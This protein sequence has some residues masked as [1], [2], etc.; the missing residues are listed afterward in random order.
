VPDEG[1][2][3]ADLRA[4]LAD[5]FRDGARPRVTDVLRALMAHAQ[6]DTDFRDR[7]RASFLYRRRDALATV[8]HRRPGARR[9][10]AQPVPYRRRHRV[11]GHLVPD[12]RDRRTTGRTAS[13]TS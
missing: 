9:A 2:F 10:A 8:L 3:A 11:R 7:F 12:P 13:S 6:L 5:T 1:S 4:F